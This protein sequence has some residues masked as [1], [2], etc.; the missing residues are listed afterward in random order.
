MDVCECVSVCCVCL[1][2]VFE[3]CLHGLVRVCLF[4]YLGG[5]CSS[6]VVNSVVFCVRVSS[7]IVWRIGEWMEMFISLV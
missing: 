7:V 6:M 2:Y 5:V 1:L 4:S 3:C